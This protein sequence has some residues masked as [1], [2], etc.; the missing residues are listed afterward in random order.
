LRDVQ[1][2]VSVIGQLSAMDQQEYNSWSEGA[3]QFA[4]NYID[5]FDYVSKYVDLFQ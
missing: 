2:Y 3:H 5:S 1:Q 4:R